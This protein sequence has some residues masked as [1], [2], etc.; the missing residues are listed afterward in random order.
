MANHGG[1]NKSENKL[2]KCVL[3]VSRTVPS[4]QT[5]VDNDPFE[6][7][8]LVDAAYFGFCGSVGPIE[9]TEVKLE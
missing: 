6:Q 2:Y 1:E 8:F 5:A 7:Y 4:I 3:F 9:Q